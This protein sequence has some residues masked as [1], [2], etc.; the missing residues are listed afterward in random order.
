MSGTR[1]NTDAV[2]ERVRVIS[3]D[4]RDDG[5]LAAALYAVLDLHDEWH[6]G[7]PF[8]GQCPDDVEALCE[9]VDVIAEKLGVPTR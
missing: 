4:F 2:R 9:V 8:V 1:T 5:P 3:D 6:G 7:K